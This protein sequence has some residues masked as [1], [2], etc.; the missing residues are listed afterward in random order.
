MAEDSY[1]WHMFD[2]AV[3]SLPIVGYYRH[4]STTS[5]SQGGEHLGAGTQAPNGVYWRDEDGG[6]AHIQLGSAVN[7]VYGLNGAG[8]TH[9]LD[10]VAGLS[11]AAGTVDQGLLF[12]T[13]PDL[14][15]PDMSSPG[16]EGLPERLE[17]ARPAMFE[18]PCRHA[19]LIGSNLEVLR[20]FQALGHITWS[21]PLRRHRRLCRLAVPICLPAQR[22]PA[23][24][25]FVER[26][27]AW[28][29]RV[30]RFCESYFTER[31]REE[32]FE[33]P[34]E[35]GYDDVK[36]DYLRFLVH[37]SRAIF[38]ALGSV[39]WTE[40]EPLPESEN[41]QALR[42]LSERDI[43]SDS[44]EVP[45][46]LVVDMDRFAA[47][48]AQAKPFIELLEETLTAEGQ[49]PELG[50]SI[51]FNT[52]NC[53]LKF[54]D[55][56]E[57]VQHG[58]WFW[59]LLEIIDGGESL[60]RIEDG[61]PVFLPPVAV[62]F[63]EPEPGEDDHGNLAGL[64]SHGLMHA[65]NIPDSGVDWASAAHNLVRAHVGGILEKAKR[66][67]RARRAHEAGVAAVDA[68]WADRGVPPPVQDRPKDAAPQDYVQSLLVGFEVPEFSFAVERVNAVLLTLLPTSPTLDI[69]LGSP[70]S[71]L[72]GE[73]PVIKLGDRHLRSASETQQRWAYFAIKVALG[74]AI[75]PTLST[76]LVIDE[77]E[78][79]LHRS[80]EATVAEGLAEISQDSRCTTIVATHSPEFLNLPDVNLI[81]ASRDRG[82]REWTP[83][84]Y[85][86]LGELG[87]R[88]ADELV[89]QNLFLIVE[90][91]HDEAVINTLFARDLARLGVHVVPL[92]GAKSGPEA[93]DS[94]MIFDF[95]DAKI[96]LLLDNVEG[97]RVAD[98]WA[99]AREFAQRGEINEAKDTVFKN[100]ADKTAEGRWIRT[101]M[102]KA[103]E[104]GKHERVNVYGL[105]E[106]DIIWYLPAA[107][108]TQGPNWNEVITTYNSEHASEGVVPNKSWVVKRYRT[109]LDPARFAEAASQIELPHTDL[110]QLMEA[111]TN[112]VR[113]GDS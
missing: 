15:H 11:R 66:V 42:Q 22:G 20:E 29:G 94:A 37:L 28:I 12:P 103:L 78:K 69:D 113:N 65:T 60:R 58:T 25:A 91:S 54:E 35:F 38:D 97:T 17:F 3:D 16:S 33:N 49:G 111:V 27:N 36:V 77:P 90:G 24:R 71:W 48:R 26:Y 39:D 7:A 84:D 30:E 44:L 41:L 85:S 100:F 83:S 45:A 102:A 50:G 19:D 68:L 9:F 88:K 5:R 101:F 31:Y 46:S 2:E 109:D 93:I 34:D 81:H 23:T 89:R 52:R 95:T 86:N 72:T 55:L 64:V 70:A 59:D 14:F 108:F 105:A 8:K 4:D 51:L 13:P 82:V 61:D 10:M 87:F 57:S 99:A 104:S 76:L 21:E 80:A 1:A 75:N 79:G 112:A 47:L 92:H 18:A 67:A 62:E 53:Q 43:D 40:S 98:A 106:P 6:F 96:M 74:Y 32:L 107:V 110:L 73:H 63:L 56:T